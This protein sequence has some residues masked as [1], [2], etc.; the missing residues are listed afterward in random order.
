[1]R[2][3]NRVAR[4]RFGVS[5]GHR[6]FRLLVSK[7]GSVRGRGRSVGLQVHRLNGASRRRRIARRGD[8]RALRRGVRVLWR[9]IDV[10][11]LSCCR[12]VRVLWRG[13]D[14]GGLCCAPAADFRVRVNG[15]VP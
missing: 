1:M 12:G 10:G 6:C 2:L 7:R 15:A 4:S 9:G 13:I 14:V 3:A 11:G 8:R 5:C